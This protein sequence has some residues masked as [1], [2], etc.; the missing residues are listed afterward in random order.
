MV[1]AANGFAF[2]NWA[3]RLPAIRDHL[4]LSAGSIGRVL[5]ALSVGSVA[6]LPLSG[7]ITRRL[8]PGSTVRTVAVI[9]AIGLTV[10]GLAPSVA[11]LAV[12]LAVMGGAVGLWDVA[13]NVEGADVERVLARS[14]MPRFHAGFSLGTVAGAGLGSLAAGAGIPVRVH[15]P[16][17]AVGTAVVGAAAVHWFL[18]RA[19]E[20]ALEEEESA[21]AAR[22]GGRILA[23]W[24][25]PRTLLIGLLVF[26]M[27][28]AEGSA[29][30]WLALAM[31]DGYGAAHALAA[32]GFGVF[33]TGM[34]LA[35]LAGPAVLARVDPV[36]VIRASALLVVSGT[37]LV[38]AG[39]QI[40]GGSASVLRYLPALAGALAWG[41]GAAMGFPM[42]MTAAAADE[43]HS[44]ARLA[45][46][47]TI[48]YTAFIAG[49][50][51]LGTFGQHVGVVWSL[52]GVCLAVLLAL[53]TAQVVRPVAQPVP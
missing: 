27:A 53:A 23:A 13:M 26:G 12:G 7:A 3:A 4:H 34:T 46:V 24:V 45:V 16:V 17:V 41:V 1:F 20:R 31:V 11:V 18:P 52:V 33:V 30:D 43:E 39:A 10:V 2:A 40:A 37:G 36:M 47:T 48:G 51:L 25:E 49:P 15:L 35:R 32:G 14:I 44:A 29:N 8:G 22:S 21:K 9:A 50:P 6:L 19:V 5:L 38:I 28:M 42:G